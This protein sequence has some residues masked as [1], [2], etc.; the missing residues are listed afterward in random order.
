VKKY[1]LSTTISQKH[2]ALL[3]K[4][5]EKYETQQKALERALECLDSN[6]MIS[7]LVTEEDKAWLQVGRDLMPLMVLMPKEQCKMWAETADMDQYLDFVDKYRPIEFTIEFYNQKPLKACTLPEV[8]DC[9]ILNCKIS[10]NVD[11]ISYADAGDYY[12]LIITHTLGI[13][14]SKCHVMLHG[15]VL[16]SYGVRFEHTL[17]ERTVFFKI[18][19]NDKTG[20]IPGKG[21]EAKSVKAA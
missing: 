8:I 5:S 3:K 12:E 1:R 11:T 4:Y 13:N 10:N 20:G 19:K 14:V 15:S 17:S 9:I 2:W 18:Y 21:K 7:S 16:R 6:S